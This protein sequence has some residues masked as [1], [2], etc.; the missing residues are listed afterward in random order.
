MQCQLALAEGFTN[1]VRHAHAGRPIDLLIDLEVQAFDD[2]LELRIWD[3]GSPFDLAQRLTAL[4]E[5]VDTDA[6]GGRGLMLM[7]RI[8]DV[9]TYTRT[10]G[11]RNCLLLVKKYEA[12]EGL[13]VR[14]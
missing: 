2:R 6:E 7:K 13:G 5:H 4:P 8:A 3:Q 10:S 1:A 12:Y 9:F 11:D 14:G